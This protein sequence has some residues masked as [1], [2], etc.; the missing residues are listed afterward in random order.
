MRFPFKAASVAAMTF[1]ALVTFLASNASLAGESA[2]VASGVMPQSSSSP[3]FSP[4]A[5]AFAPLREVAQPITSS[6]DLSARPFAGQMLPGSSLANL[7]SSYGAGDALDEQSKCLAGA[8]Y[9]ESKGESLSGQLAVARVIINRAHSGRFANSLCGV[10]Y[11][12]GQFSFVRGRTIPSINTASR[13]WHEAVA[14]SRIALEN[15][16]TNVAEGAL[17][18]HARR[19]SPG[20]RLQKVVAID[21]HIFYR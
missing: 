5:V 14:I 16:W 7:V 6:T 12:P 9:Y 15:S 17:F 19:V 1:S 8:V 11:Q 4:A 20:W 21:N 13:D 10:V 2:A 18:F 3:S